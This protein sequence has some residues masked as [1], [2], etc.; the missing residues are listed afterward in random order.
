MNWLNNN[1]AIDKIGLY[2]WY[3]L[4]FLQA[5]YKFG[6]LRQIALFILLFCIIY[7]IYQGKRI[8]LIESPVFPVLAIALIVVLWIVLVSLVGPYPIESIKTIRKDF[9]VQILLLLAPYFYIKNI[10]DV[11][12]VIHIILAG[13]F[14]LIILSSVEIILNSPNYIYEIYELRK[15]NLFYD[16]YGGLAGVYVPLLV[17]FIYFKKHKN[18]KLTILYWAM[19]VISVS[20]LFL[21]GSRA[22]LL[23]AGLSSAL[24]LI[25]FKKWRILLGL[26]SLSIISVLIIQN[27]NMGY[28]SRYSSL[29]SRET[30]TTNQGLSQRI[31]VWQGTID[32]I[33]DRPFLGYGY[34]WKKLA[35]VINEN[36]FAEYWAD[37]PDIRNYYLSEKGGEIKA[38]YGRVNPHNYFIQIAFEIGI[39][40]L[41][42]VMA[43]WFSI[44]WLLVK[45]FKHDKKDTGSFVIAYSGLLFAYMLSNIAN[46]YWTG[47]LSNIV[48]A[49]T[50]C[51]LVIGNT[52]LPS[53]KKAL[54]EII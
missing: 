41:L 51:L 42:L 17:A 13:F 8:S 11:Y 48:L 3:V 5:F 54:N 35:T 22:P 25:L 37:R 14:A 26:I 23:A 24:L 7:E 49:C 19:L 30:Y 9:L 43:F 50:G 28:L 46:G 6:A 36:N 32:V 31:S 52:I 27:M 18:T 44:I 38:S 10:N 40:G 4:L 20:L 21:Y 33:K 53:N 39:V 16:G 47:P 45:I 2:S 29:A 15:N 34:G 12:K 1:N